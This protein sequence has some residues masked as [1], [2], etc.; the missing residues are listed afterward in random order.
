MA[1]GDERTETNGSPEG[2][3]APATD[4]P[5]TSSHQADLVQLALRRPTLGARVTSRIARSPAVGP[6]ADRVGRSW[7]EARIACECEDV[8]VAEISRALEEGVRS[9]AQLAVRTGLG[10]GTCGGARCLD[11]VA[12]HLARLTGRPASET[13]R[14]AAALVPVRAGV[15]GPDRGLARTCLAYSR[16][17]DD[18]FDDGED[19]DEPELVV[20]T[21]RPRGRR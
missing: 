10:T 18:V 21:T 14:E 17:G 1:S 16:L 3:S 2:A 4:G 5:T 11:A 13:L 7:A 9:M 19:D 20:Q 6:L 15:H 8:L 12:L